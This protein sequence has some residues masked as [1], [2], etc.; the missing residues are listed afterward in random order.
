MV[1]GRLIEAYSDSTANLD[2]A[3]SY[4]ARFGVRQRTND[5]WGCFLSVRGSRLNKNQKKRGP[6]FGRATSD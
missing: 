1:Q 4:V 5:I 3:L 2:I 6:I